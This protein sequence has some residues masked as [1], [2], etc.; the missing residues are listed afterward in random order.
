VFVTATF[1]KSPAS[2]PELRIG[3]SAGDL[4]TKSPLLLGMAP[5]SIAGD[6]IKGQHP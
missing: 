4:Q 3:K 6:T 2:E 5:L 1:V